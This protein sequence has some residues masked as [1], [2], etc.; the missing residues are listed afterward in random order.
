[1]NSKNRLVR[2]D[3]RLLALGLFSIALLLGVMTYMG[4]NTLQSMQTETRT[5]ERTIKVEERPYD[6]KQFRNVDDSYAA[7][8]YMNDEA[9]MSGNHESMK[10][11]NY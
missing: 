5:A 4:P 6:F 3:Q 8:D 10:Y 2:S 7:E 11:P 9:S 1:M